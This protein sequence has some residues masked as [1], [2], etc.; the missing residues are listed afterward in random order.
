MAFT[1]PS[2]ILIVDSEQAPVFQEV[3]QVDPRGRINLLPRWIKRLGWL[4]VEPVETQ[5]LMVFEQPGRIS[6]RNW[7]TDGKNVAQ[8]YLELMSHDDDASREALRL[9]QDRYQKLIIPAKKRCSLG[10]PALVHLGLRVTPQDEQPIYVAVFPTKID[11]LSP[12][13]RERLLLARHPF[14]DDLP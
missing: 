13:C 5:A 6:L 3:T 10:Q 4:S 11:L 14:L 12:N 1:R 8:R 9:I 7:E 2:G